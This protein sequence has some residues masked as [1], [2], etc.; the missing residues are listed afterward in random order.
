MSATLFYRFYK[1]NVLEWDDPS[2]STVYYMPLTQQ[3]DFF[4]GYRYVVTSSSIGYLAPDIVRLEVPFFH[5]RYTLVEDKQ[6]YVLLREAEAAIRTQSFDASQNAL[7]ISSLSREFS[8]I[9]RDS[10]PDH[11]EREGY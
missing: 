3:E 4:F 7:R 8:K 6:Y 11:L 9:V 1:K 10:I 2:H 5:S